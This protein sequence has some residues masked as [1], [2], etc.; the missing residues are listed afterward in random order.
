MPLKGEFLRQPTFVNGGKRVL[1]G[2]VRLGA[3][4]TFD[5]AFQ[6]RHGVENR[7]DL[8][9]DD[10]QD[11]N[12]NSEK[13]RSDEK[14]K[15]DDFRLPIE[16]IETT[17]GAC[18]TITAEHSAHRFVIDRIGTIRHN[19]VKRHRFAQIFH[20]FRFARA[21][22]S[23]R[24]TAAT[25][26]QSDRQ[27]HVTT[28]KSSRNS[29][30]MQKRS[31]LPIGERRDDQTARI[32]EIFA[33]VPESSDRLFDDDF[34]FSTVKSQ[35]LLPFEGRFALDLVFNQIVD[36]VARMDFDRHQRN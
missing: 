36:H 1:F 25:Q 11:F 5:I 10:G 29:F 19:D 2:H 13:R 32:A 16:L 34:V 15:N 17:P 24:R 18:L 22:R 26:R 9:S 31:C 12:V 30:S 20:R 14:E 27:R 3:N 4:G 33:S 23:F 21:G 7:G 28:E 35:L 8:L 6:R